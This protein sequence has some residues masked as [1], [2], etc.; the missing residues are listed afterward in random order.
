MQNMNM[1]C[2]QSYTMVHNVIH[3]YWSGRHCSGIICVIKIMPRLSSLERGRAIG[4]LQARVHQNV[5]AATFGVSQATI[6]KLQ[7]RYQDTDNVRN[8]PRSGRPHVTTT[9]S[10][11]RI[12][13]IAARRRYVTATTIQDEV[14]QPGRQCTSAQTVRR[15]RRRLHC[16]GF[17]ARL[18]AIVPDMNAEHKHQRLVCCR[19]RRRWNMIQWGNILF[20]DESRFCL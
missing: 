17:R 18:P 1:L 20:S 13:T 7:R 4:Q 2:A 6:S 11:R 9:A 14:R 12:E 5:V 3:Q 15:R 16:A 8:R 19:H 10:D